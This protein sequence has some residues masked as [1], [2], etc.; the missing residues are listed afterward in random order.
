MSADNWRVCPRCNNNIKGSF[1]RKAEESYGKVSLEKFNKIMKEAMK[2]EKQ[3]DK[4]KFTLREDF[5]IG[6]LGDGKFFIDYTA[7]CKICKFNHR[8]KKEEQLNF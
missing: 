3:Y 5:E 1:K 6:I 4:N 7:S 2:K 8:V